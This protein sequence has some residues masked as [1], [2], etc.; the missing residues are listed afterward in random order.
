MEAGYSAASDG[1][2]Q[3]GEH[4]L[5][6]H[7]KAG[8]GRQVHSGLCHKYAHNSSQ[9]HG[10]QQIAVE[11]VTGL[12][13]RPNRG[14]GRN[15]HIDKHDDMPSTL[16][17]IHGEIQT[18]NNGTHKHNDSNHRI[19]PLMELA[20]WCGLCSLQRRTWRRNPVPHRKTRRR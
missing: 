13:Q 1:N 6:I 18:D 7:H 9:N 11:I 4:T 17:D 15:E 14:N 3:N 12:E 8:K 5:A 10:H 19:D 2:K 20:I 16:I